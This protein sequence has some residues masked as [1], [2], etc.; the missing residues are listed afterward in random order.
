M[1]IKIIVILIIVCLFCGCGKKAKKV[2]VDRE[3][4]D[5]FMQAVKQGDELTAAKILEKHHDLVFLQDKAKWTPLHHA[6]SHGHVNV[7]GLILA[8]K[9]DVNAKS[10]NGRTPLHLAAYD[11]KPEMVELLLKHKADINA[12]NKSGYTPLTTAKK[13]GNKDVETLLRKKGARE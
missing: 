13:T 4:A 7:T 9:A 12:K 11:G 8:Y 3:T 1:K 2:E 5:K 10:V 6:V